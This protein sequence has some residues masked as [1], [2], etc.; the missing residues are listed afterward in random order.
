MNRFLSAA[1]LFSIAI[2]IQCCQSSDQSKKNTDEKVITFSLKNHHDSHIYMYSCRGTRQML[3]D[4][5]PI[6]DGYAS[7]II[8]KETPAGLYRFIIDKAPVDLLIAGENISVSVDAGRVEEPIRITE[9]KENKCLY[10]FL[11]EYGNLSNSEIVSCD[12]ILSLKSRYLNDTLPSNARSHIKLL[13]A[14]DTCTKEEI[15]LN[16]TLL[17]SPYTASVIQA[18]TSYK[19]KNESAEYVLQK[20]LECS[21]STPEVRHELYTAFWQAGLASN[22]PSMLNAI[23]QLKEADFIDAYN[24]LK[25]TDGFTCIEAGMSFP[26]Q[27]LIKDFSPGIYNLYYIIIHDNEDLSDSSELMNLTQKLNKSQEKYFTISNIDL[28]EN[29][30]R[31]IGYVSG[32]M[33]LM[34]GKNDILA[35]KWIGKEDIQTIR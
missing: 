27:S 17:N 16:E 9:S 26:T 13:L 15:C 11:Y 3:I 19:C 31:T 32:P 7:V 20:I 35:D 12:K 21:E 29:I 10:D 23:L 14:S 25:I 4:S 5:L 30:Q 22:Q 24:K 34:I 1:L 33:V 28:A 6:T 18:V 8:P 2:I